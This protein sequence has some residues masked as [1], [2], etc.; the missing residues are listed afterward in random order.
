MSV[1]HGSPRLWAVVPA[2]GSGRRFG[3]DI[4][5][6]YLTIEG[7]PIMTLT[8]NRLFHLPL[9]GCV[10]AIAAEDTQ[11]ATLSYDHPDRM[12]FVIGGGERMDSVLSGL[13]YL[14][15]HAHDDDWVL[16]HDVA[17][18]CIAPDSLDRLVSELREDAVGGILAIP[19]RDTLKRAQSISQGLPEI[20]ETVSREQLW[21]AQTPQMFRYGL[22]RD[23]LQHAQTGKLHVTDEAS[24]IELAGLTP[25]LVEGR[26]DNLK[27]TY[28]DDL[29]LA[30]LILA[31]Q[32]R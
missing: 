8:L 7:E 3:G 20:A 28:A 23:A 11:A 5:K 17:R 26:P 13:H 21:M 31:G 29:P 32:C 30:R 19:V 2:A 4:P 10:V 18:P 24:A 15:D 6:Q 16:V 27:I 1:V 9:A 12:H 14:I 22:L 25:K